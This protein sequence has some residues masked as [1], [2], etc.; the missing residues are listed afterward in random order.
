MPCAIVAVVI[1]AVVIHAMYR[2]W[3]LGW[4]LPIAQAHSLYT[5]HTFKLIRCNSV[6]ISARCAVFK[7]DQRCQD[8]V[9]PV[10]TRGR[11]LD[12]KASPAC[13]SI[14]ELSGLGRF[15]GCPHRFCRF[16]GEVFWGKGLS[17][18]HFCPNCD[19]VFLKTA[20]K[21]TLFEKLENW[22]LG[23][24]RANTPFHLCLLLCTFDFFVWFDL[25]I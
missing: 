8:S 1:V 4:D 18:G 14:L 12:S 3:T 11:W 21:S 10:L 24:E 5:I 25:F 6:A 16:H 13:S 23:H 17:H 15:G 20:P 7:L 22:S 2:E 9:S 19:R